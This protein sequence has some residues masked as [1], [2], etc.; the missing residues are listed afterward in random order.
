MSYDRIGN[1][2]V[3]INGEKVNI[4]TMVNK[5]KNELK[6]ILPE[7]ESDKLINMLSHCRNQYYG[8]LYYGRRANPKNLNRIRELTPNERLVYDYLLKNQFNPCTTYRW[9]IATRIPSDVKD[10]LIKG[11]ISVRKA[12]EISS[13]RRRVKESNLGLLMIEELRTIMMGL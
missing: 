1:T 2:K 11:Q 12:M 9:F 3:R 8:K 7:I 5:I 6:A 13:N 4:F 10:K